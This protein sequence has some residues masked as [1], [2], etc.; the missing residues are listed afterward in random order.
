V[1]GNR[2]ASSVFSTLSIDFVMMMMMTTPLPLFFPVSTL[3]VKET[4]EK[5]LFPP[6][7]FVL[8]RAELFYP[9]RQMAFCKMLVRWK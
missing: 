1:A 9:W 3:F 4:K 2:E 6:F 8:L 7:F 5:L